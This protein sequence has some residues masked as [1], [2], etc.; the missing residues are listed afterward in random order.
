MRIVLC[1]GEHG[2]AVI[3]G[4]VDSAPV[5]GEPVEVRDARM[6]LRW[7]AACSGLLGLAAVGPRGDT[8]ITHA[9]PRVVETRW[10]EWVAVTDAA[11]DALDGWAPWLG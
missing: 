8:R 7:D 6:V 2:R 5:P 1:C 9:V 3:V 10:Q 4:D 11:A